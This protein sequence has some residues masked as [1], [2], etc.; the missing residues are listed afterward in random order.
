MVFKRRVRRSFRDVFVQFFW[1]RGGWRRAFEYV[2]HR[3]R[4]LPDTPEKIARGVWA[5]VFVSF[6]PLFGL[7]FLTAA[8]IAKLMRGNILAALLATFFGNPLTFLPIGILSINTGYV[9]LG[10]RPTTS[11]ARYMPDLFYGVW[12]DI[13]G[14]LRALF[15]FEEMD[16]SRFATFVDTVFLP[17][18]IG[19]IIPG[20]IFATLSYFLSLKLI[21]AYQGHRRRK[22]SE[23]LAQ[24]K[25]TPAPPA[26]LP[27][28]PR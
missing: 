7:H 11:V 20:I 10:G 6:T 25:K 26:D 27:G 12:A 17:Y 18:L 15:R 28:A 3:V 5:G 19:G 1:P 8:L 4:R 23:K 22:L 16:W 2:K 21:G 24:L 14:N 9:L 13:F